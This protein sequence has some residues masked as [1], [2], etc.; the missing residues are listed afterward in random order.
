MKAIPHRGDPALRRAILPLL[1]AL[2]GAGIALA[3]AAED[4]S[5]DVHATAYN[6]LPGQTAGR[7]SVAAWGD[8][9]YPG[10]K[11]IAVSRDLL[12]LGLTRGVAARIEG[13]SGEYLVLDK[14]ATRWR[15][16]ID[17]YMGEDVGAARTW[18]VQPV[19]IH[20]TVPE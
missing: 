13:L 11:A 19:R 17:I 3:A 1:A 6:S 14:M 20:W 7:P 4:H 12:D 16:K 9:M 8:P 18:G 10:L 15:R 5:L 2:T